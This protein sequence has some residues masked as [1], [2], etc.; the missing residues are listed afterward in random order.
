MASDTPTAT[1]HTHGLDREGL[2]HAYRTM[3]LMRLMHDRATNLQRQGRIHSWLGCFGQ[4]AAIVASGL[5]MA[6]EDWIFPSYREHAVALVRGIPARK[7]FDHLYGN[8]ADNAKGRNLPPEYT[9]R[10]INYVSISAPVGTQIPQAVGVAMAAK[11]RKD[12]IAVITYFGDG[13][14]STADAHTGMNFAGVWKAPVIFFCQNNGWAISVPTSKQT[15]AETIASR[16]VGYGFEGV[17]VDGND[18]LAT[19]GVTKAAA[20][21]ARQG[22]GPTLIEAMTY[23]VGPHSTS[24]DPT[25]YRD[26]AEVAPWRDRDPIAVFERQLASLGLWDEAFGQE[27]RAWAT[28]ELQEA[29]REASEVPAPALETI[30]D[31]VY[32]ETPWHLREQRDAH[33]ALRA[34]TKATH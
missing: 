20:D 15:A 34:Q 12:P 5:A 33:M 28:K 30:F 6:K 2:H 23:R 13:T 16:A 25:A 18:F 27:V 1:V 24:D 7:L 9:F 17:R 32:A 4:E 11:L 3:V 8:A 21:K 14:S 19:Y 22:G 31:E 26:D 10:E 29:A